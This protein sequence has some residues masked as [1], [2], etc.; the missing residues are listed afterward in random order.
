MEVKQLTFEHLVD[1]ARTHEVNKKNFETIAI[2][3]DVLNGI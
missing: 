3:S 2:N 1:E